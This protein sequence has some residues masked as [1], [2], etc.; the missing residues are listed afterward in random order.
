MSIKSRLD[1]L[2][3]NRLLTWHDGLVLLISSVPISTMSSLLAEGQFP[4]LPMILLG[5]P[6][7]YIGQ[8]IIVGF[9]LFLNS[10]IYKDRSLDLVNAIRYVALIAFI[11]SSLLIITY[12]FRE[13]PDGWYRRL[14][15]SF[16]KTR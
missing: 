16:Y 13:P 9:F 14:D 10:I 15:P 12:V 1:R 3:G 2:L 5:I 7:G 6:A 11:T 8:C 4:S